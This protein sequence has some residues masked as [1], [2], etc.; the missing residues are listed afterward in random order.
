MNQNVHGVTSVRRIANE[1]QGVSK[2]SVL[3]LF[4]DEKF[5]SYKPRKVQQLLAG[6][7]EKRL[8]F[9]QFALSHLDMLHVLWTDEAYFT[10]N[11]TI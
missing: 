7:H 2:S 8:T 9:A 6:D 3:R 4:H 5:K 11:G 10:L 1:I